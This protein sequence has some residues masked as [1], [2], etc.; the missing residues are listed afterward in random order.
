MEVS[1]AD[2]R[3]IDKFVLKAGTA[4]GFKLKGKYLEPVDQSQGVG[5]RVPAAHS[6]KNVGDTEFYEVLFQHPPDN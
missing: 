6:A 5:M 1:D 4:S 3:V 2:G